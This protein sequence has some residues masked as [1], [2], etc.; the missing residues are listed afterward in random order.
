MINLIIPAIKDIRNTGYD[1][2]D[3]LIER[4][5]REAA[6]SRYAAPSELPYMLIRQAGT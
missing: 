6:R 1:V 4:S 5:I 2:P 3:S